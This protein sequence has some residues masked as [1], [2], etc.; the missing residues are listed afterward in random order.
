MKLIFSKPT[1][2][3]NLFMPRLIKGWLEYNDIFVGDGSTDYPTFRCT[4][5]ACHEFYD[6]HFYDPS[7]WLKNYKGHEPYFDKLKRFF[8]TVHSCEPTD[9]QQSYRWEIDPDTQEQVS[10]PSLRIWIRPQSEP[11]HK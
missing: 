2:D 5:N 8:T 4:Y 6:M 9:I 3:F 1:E 10:V 7:R 11:D